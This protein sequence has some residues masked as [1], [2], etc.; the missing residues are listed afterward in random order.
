MGA[1]DPKNRRNLALRV[2]SALV[3]FPFAVWLTIVGGRPFAVLAAG[4]AVVA[5]AELVLMFTTLGVG[6]AFGIAVAGAIPLMAAFGESGELLPGWSG[7][8]LACAT[9]VLLALFLFRRGPLEAVPRAVAVVTLSWLYCGVLLASVVGLRLRH[10]VAWVILAF[11]VTWANDTAAYFAGHALG[12]HKLYERISPKKTWEG[13]AGGAL[14]SVAG[15]LA[16][17]ALFP[18]LGAG[19]SVGMAVVVGLG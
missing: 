14:G 8:A 9:V 4:G 7:L 3:L 6:E 17:R 19:L 5:A 11:V 2:G 12:R 10:G 13:F 18:S 16:T 15:A 1:L